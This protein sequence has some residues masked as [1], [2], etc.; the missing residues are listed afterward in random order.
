MITI[1]IACDCGAYQLPRVIIDWG[2]IRFFSLVENYRPYPLC[3][4]IAAI[5]RG[6]PVTVIRTD[7]Y[8]APN[9]ARSYD[10]KI[11]DCRSGGFQAPSKLDGLSPPEHRAGEA[12]RRE[13]KKVTRV[14]MCGGWLCQNMKIAAAQMKSYGQDTATA[15]TPPT[16]D[17]GCIVRCVLCVGVNFFVWA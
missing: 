11:A 5:V 7:T 14:C 4:E 16:P 1:T 13:K 10:L 17:L 6:S 12:R 3:L 8:C 15:R 9:Q 2:G